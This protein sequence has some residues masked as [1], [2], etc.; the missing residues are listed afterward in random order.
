MN[1]FNEFVKNSFENE[2]AKQ[3][4]K[5]VSD[6]LIRL[7]KSKLFITVNLTKKFSWL[8][9][10]LYKNCNTF[11]KND[12]LD[13][14]DVENSSFFSN[15]EE[16]FD[17]DLISTDENSYQF[18]L[19]ENT[20]IILALT[21]EKGKNSDCWVKPVLRVYTLNNDKSK[22]ILKKFIR[23]MFQENIKLLKEK[24]NEIYYTYNRSYD[25]MKG[26]Q[27]VCKRSFDDVFIPEAQKT[28]IKNVL[29]KYKSKFNWFQEH[30]LINHF[31]IILYG[32]PGTGKSSLAQAISTYLEAEMYVT[33]GDSLF[34]I[35]DII[36]HFSFQQIPVSK[37]TY[38]VIIIEDI[39]SGL[40]S[41]NER[42]KREMEEIENTLKESNE[43]HSHE[44]MNTIR[45][46]NKG[47]GEVLNSLDGIRAPYNTVYIFTT[48]RVDALDP[49]LI[50]P[51]RIDY[52]L[53]VKNVNEETLNQFTKKF[54][55]KEIPSDFKIKEGLTFAELQLL[56]M[57]DTPFEEFLNKISLKK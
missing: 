44:L 11:V 28:E 6:Y 5:P 27:L 45:N 39:D 15:M 26:K 3:I 10:W 8:Q 24:E 53:E 19:Y 31:G 57:V 38:R 43:Y 16:G 20:P 42:R 41:L 50:R 18:F 46:Y 52:A 48:N 23:N 55:N 17:S 29:D 1:K 36:N 7:L 14:K 12:K 4:T 47:L 34:N 13:I 54:Y 51:G 33:T 56:V 40:V 32:D 2:F 9:N 21:P 22:K 49:A 25:D 30:K 37:D 35:S